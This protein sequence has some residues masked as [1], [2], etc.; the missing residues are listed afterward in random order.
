M[1]SQLPKISI[2][3]ICYNAAATIEK[4]LQSVAAQDYPHIEYL[5]I[6]G[7]STDNTLAIVEQYQEQVTKVVSEPD[8]GI[9]DAMNKGLAHATGEYIW[10]VHADDQIHAP[11]TLS[12]IM[13]DHQNEDFIYGKALLV[14]EKGEE[15]S[16]ET[17]K[18]HPKAST[19]TWK[20]MK[21]GMA[22][23]HQAMLVRRTLAPQYDLQYRYVADF[24]WLIRVLKKSQ[25]VR[26]TGIYWCRF[27]EG[28]ISTQHRN[29]SLKERFAILKKHFGLV[30]TLWQHALITLKALKRGSMS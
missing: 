7:K 21:Q 23:S 3:T 26:D 30:P 15:R 13:A 20:T 6:D 14:N 8:Q 11:D 17:R 4:T 12:N 29:A 19:L 2:I 24:D 1:S 5:I 16:L 10:Y 25:T 9:Y 22:I 18:P 27:A 28:G